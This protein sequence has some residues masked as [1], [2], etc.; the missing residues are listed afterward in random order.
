[1][2]NQFCW[3]ELL[4]SDVEA[5]QT[6]YCD[7][8]GW[9]CAPVGEA[10]RDYRFFSYEGRGAGGLMQL[11]QEAEAQGA[12]P[13]W[14]GYI[15][16]DN[17]DAEVEKILAAGGK[18]YRPAETLAGMGRFAVVADPQ[19]AAFAL[20]QDLS[21]R[22]HTPVAPMSPGHVGWHELF[23]DDVEKAFAFYAQRFGLDQ[24]RRPRHG[25]DGD[26]PAFRNRRHARRRHD[27][28]AR[29][30][31]QA[32]L[33]LLSRR[34]GA[35]LGDRQ[36][37]EGRWQDRQRADGSARRRLDRPGFRSAGGVFLAGRREKVMRAV[38]MLLLMLAGARAAWAGED[39]CET[40]KDA[41]KYNACLASFGPVAGP[42][43][44]TPM[45]PSQAFSHASRGHVAKAV[46]PKPH[47]PH[48]TRKANGR[49]RIEILR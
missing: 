21:H 32:V 43:K 49:M 29:A 19:G 42:K 23:T 6:F 5:A 4:T 3:V 35:Q 20:W 7:V 11:P 45:P 36:G 15:A 30:H 44:L 40:I 33:E 10:G 22:E 38:V 37:G 34:A 46:A 17:V 16:S 31:A 39:S 48:L 27:A 2:A 24:G 28:A 47:G 13:S 25:A 14:F 8:I 26:L 9:T 1:M 18:L 12:P 41:D